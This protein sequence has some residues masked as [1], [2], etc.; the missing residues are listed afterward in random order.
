MIQMELRRNKGILIVKPLGSLAV[1]DF[2]VID[3][4]AERLASLWAKNM[5]R[6]EGIL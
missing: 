3:R 1:E 2:V 4:W 5:K 6:N